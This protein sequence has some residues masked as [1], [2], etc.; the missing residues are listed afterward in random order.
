[1]LRRSL[2][3]SGSWVLFSGASTKQNPRKQ[4]PTS[5]PTLKRCLGRQL[6]VGWEGGGG[7]AAGGTS[8]DGVHIVV[9]W[10]SC[11]Q[12]VLAVTY[13]PPTYVG[14][15]PCTQKRP[16]S[17]TRMPGCR[18]ER[19]HWWITTVVAH[20]RDVRAGEGRGGAGSMANMIQMVL[21]ILPHMYAPGVTV[22]RSKPWFNGLLN[23]RGSS[24]VAASAVGCIPGILPLTCRQAS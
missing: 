11:R 2:T 16:A 7:G 9:V 18:L 3:V 21:I 15:I 6:P 22:T 13:L 1:M 14:S 24:S 19:C 5:L 20:T 12:G 8:I 17:H 23:I 10:R 4:T